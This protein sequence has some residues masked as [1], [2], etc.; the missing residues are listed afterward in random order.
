MC[1]AQGIPLRGNEVSDAI[2]H[3]RVGVF[4]KKARKK[5]RTTQDADLPCVKNIS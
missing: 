4:M 1:P 5:Y 3:T 2:N